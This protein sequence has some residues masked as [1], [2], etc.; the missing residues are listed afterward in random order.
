MGCRPL[1]CYCSV[2]SVPAWPSPAPKAPH[3]TAS[4]LPVPAAEWPLCSEHFLSPAELPAWLARR[5]S[6]PLS[7]PADCQNRITGRARPSIQGC[8]QHCVSPAACGFQWPC[9]RAVL[10]GESVCVP[11]SPGRGPLSP[12]ILVRI[13]RQPWD[14]SLA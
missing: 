12:S 3:R 5:R 8:G 7:S 1:S 9:W 2:P 11:A 10:N 13:R 4:S 6:H 14:P